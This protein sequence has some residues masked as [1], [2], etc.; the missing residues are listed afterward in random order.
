MIIP[1]IIAARSRLSQWL[2]KRLLLPIKS[3]AL[4]MSI[5]HYSVMNSHTLVTATI[6]ASIL[7]KMSIV[8]GIIGVNHP[9]IQR[10]NETVASPCFPI[11]GN[12]I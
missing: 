1:S 8:S 4:T 5:P 12:V 10:E 7:I 6:K 2:C 11:M 9:Y 3:I